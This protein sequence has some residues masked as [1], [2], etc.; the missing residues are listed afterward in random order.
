MR[1]RW[2]KDPAETGLRRVTAPPLGS[3][4]HDGS[5]TY[6]RV[7]ALGRF[8]EEGWFYVIGWDSGLPYYNSHK[9]PS[10]TEQQAKDDAMERVV[11]GLKEQK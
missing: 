1:L 8:G 5:K 7:S 6:A 11:R 10:M 3:R 9:E 2:K 4:L